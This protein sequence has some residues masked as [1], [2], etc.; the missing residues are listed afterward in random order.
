LTI[1]NCGVV[2]SGQT[3]NGDLSIA[4]G[5]HTTS[6]STPCVTIRDSLIHGT[7]SI[8]GGPL[9]MTSVEVDAPTTSDQSSVVGSNFYLWQVNVHGGAK[10]AIQCSGYCAVHDSWVHDF[11]LAGASHYDGFG[12]NGTGGAPFVIDHNTIACDF[13]ASAAGA[14][15]GC[16]GDIG[17]FGDFATISNVTITNNLLVGS[18][19]PSYCLYAGTDPGKAY[20]TASNV[21][22]TG[23]TFQRGPT[24]KCGYYGPVAKWAP[25]N[26]NTWNNNTWDDGTPLNP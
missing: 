19:S 6:A 7:V 25:G 10:G 4:A 2:I 26:G 21:T 14:T 18:R 12:S 8:N 9:V 17:L 20:P 11:Y 22:I 24:G 16:S 15:G 3:I 1:R 13:Y 23:N 5:N